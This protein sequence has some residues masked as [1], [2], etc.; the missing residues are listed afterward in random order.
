[1]DI[2]SEATILKPYCVIVPCAFL[3]SSAESTTGTPYEVKEQVEE[4]VN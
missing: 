2:L 4:T 3:S 1:M